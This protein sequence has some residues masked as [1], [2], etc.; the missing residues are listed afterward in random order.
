[1]NLD[2]VTP[3]A[4]EF[5]NTYLISMFT[6]LNCPDWGCEAAK[7]Q[8]S[9]QIKEGNSNFYKEVYAIKDRFND[10]SWIKEQFKFTASDNKVY[11]SSSIRKIRIR[12][13]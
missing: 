4:T 8:L 12:L 11:V 13:K 7:D 1:M 5:G 2:F 10:K 6:L 9:V 3:I